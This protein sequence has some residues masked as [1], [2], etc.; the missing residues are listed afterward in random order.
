MKRFMFKL[1]SALLIA[2]VIVITL[3]LNAAAGMLS[4][5][6]PQTKIDL[7]KDSVN[8]LSEATLDLLDTLSDSNK[9]I[10]I[11]YLK[12]END[13]NVYI[14]DTI[15]NFASR[16]GNINY[17]TI[18]YVKDPAFIR[19]YGT[20]AQGLYEGSLIVESTDNEGNLIKYRPISYMDMVEYD[21]QYGVTGFKLESRLTNAI[22]YV[23][24]DETAKAYFA[25]GHGE[26]DTSVMKSAL[27]AQ[28]IEAQDFDIKTGAVPSDADVL[29]ITSPYYDFTP[30]EID[31]IDRYLDGGGNLCV[32]IDVGVT[33]PALE[34]YFAE[35]GLKFEF[36][37][38]GEGASEYR[39]G[40]DTAG[41]YFYA[42]GANHAVNKDF[43]DDNLGLFVPGARSITVSDVSGIDNS[44]LLYTSQSGF[45]SA[46][47]SEMQISEE[48]ESGSY[49]VAQ[50]LEKPVGENY[51]KTA[52]VLAVGSPGIWGVTS[53]GDYYAAAAMEQQSLANRAFLL[54]SVSYMSG[55]EDSTILI[56]TKDISV[57]LLTLTQQQQRIYTIAL[58]LALPL[59][60]LLLGLVVWLKR[61]N[62]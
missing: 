34:S 52:R 42:Q 62:R 17:E 20:D 36:D 2:G 50:L 6:F 48:T 26:P 23:T 55:I 43:T 9:L 58:S 61:K 45:A 4:E 32:A 5:K 7:T 13:E 15:N 14:R 12:N 39:S 46:I 3:L 51:D 8:E 25:V 41:Y 10:N 27:A 33:L 37:V 30:Q 49:N 40:I 35:W 22:H 29:F 54:G 19:R 59:A 57:E 24:S 11:Y 1:N 38:V 16:C 31:E 21:N 28:N 47:T 18:Y 56:D 53:S 44:V 60:A